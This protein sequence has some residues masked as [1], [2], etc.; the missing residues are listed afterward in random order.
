MCWQCSSCLVL[1]VGWPCKGD[2]WWLVVA[3]VFPLRSVAVVVAAV[4]VEN[5]MFGPNKTEAE[6]AVVCLI[7]D[8]AVVLALLAAVVVLE[9]LTVAVVADLAWEVM[10]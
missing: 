7:N 1:F 4:V 5:T 9:E 2:V 3:V 10:S 6:I 8:F